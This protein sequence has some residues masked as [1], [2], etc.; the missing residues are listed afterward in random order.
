MK[1]EVTG[2]GVDSR[3]VASHGH[4]GKTGV[5]PSRVRR[6]LSAVLLATALLPVAA[7]AQL[8]PPDEDWRTI[9]TERARVTFPV[10]IEALARRAAYRAEAALQALDRQAR[11]TGVIRR[12]IE[13]LEIR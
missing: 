3:R 4:G 13:K 11:G 7:H 2:L 12:R 5:W 8:P 1:R 10:R 9:E 6:G